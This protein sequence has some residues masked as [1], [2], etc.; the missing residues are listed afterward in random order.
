MRAVAVAWAAIRSLFGAEPDGDGPL[1]LARESWRPARASAS[2]ATVLVVGTSLGLCAVRGELVAGA[3][4]VA[5]AGLVAA[6]LALWQ[7][8]TERTTA[9]AGVLLVAG[10]FGLAGSIV[11]TLAVE[12]LTDVDWPLAGT[13]VPLPIDV[14]VA[15]ATFVG[16][17][18][19]FVAV[20]D[21]FTPD[22][23]TVA[24]TSLVYTLVPVVGFL[25]W[26][27]MGQ[28]GG[29]RVLG[30]WVDPVASL[31]FEPRP[32][33]VHLLVVAATVLVAGL[34]AFVRARPIPPWVRQPRLVRAREWMADRQSTIYG[35]LVVLVFVSVMAALLQLGGG[36]SLLL[37][38][39][40]YSVGV[41]VV[42]VGSSVALRSLLLA[43]GVGLFVAAAAPTVVR[44]VLRHRRGGLYRQAARWTPGLLLVGAIAVAPL[45]DVTRG[46]F[47]RYGT[48]AGFEGIRVQLLNA[49]AGEA[50]L[51]V[52]LLWAFLLVGLL[53]FWGGGFVFWWTVA[54]TGLVP[55]EGG[56]FA[57]ASGS[58]FLVAVLV[59]MA[60]G[61]ARYLF[62]GT[63]I[64]LVAWDVGEFSTTLG[65][66]V[67]R[68]AP[69]RQGELVHSFAAV[70]VGTVGVALAFGLFA[71]AGSVSTGAPR[72]VLVLA[73][74]GSL[75]GSL[76]LLATLRG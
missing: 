70:G 71:V 18:S 16:S 60:E 39:L 68:L 20:Q 75:L 48:P 21:R 43:A 10:A 1:V 53:L 63:A 17:L 72:D 64:A 76:L 8:P 15:V 54:W 51:L 26:A 45:V 65:R 44:W 61:S 3:L 23:V 34:Y 12:P 37:D 29:W 36:W 73:L 31:L 52:D 13:V 46:V 35:W 32:P 2:L 57:V 58:V 40:P 66:E 25:G 33:G 14:V 50:A 7:R 4:A 27:V 6:A 74:V 38:D 59:T 22:H 9:V 49:P 30:G 56:G 67:G 62:V 28:A 55:R 24:V 41:M 42:V 5:T 19:A 69:T 11:A 47:A